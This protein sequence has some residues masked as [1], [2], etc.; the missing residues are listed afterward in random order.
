MEYGTCQNNSL[1]KPPYL[2]ET[3]VT[4]LWVLLVPRMK[5]SINDMDADGRKHSFTYPVTLH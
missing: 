2:S 5:P 4:V 3:I 1:F